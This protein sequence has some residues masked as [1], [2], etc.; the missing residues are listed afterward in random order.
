MGLDSHGV[1][2]VVWYVDEVLQGKIRPGAEIVVEKETGASAVL[3]GGGN[4][5]AVAAARATEHAVEKARNSGL[6]CVTVHNCHHV[7]RLGAFTES[8][9][10]DD[11]MICLATASW[12]VAGHWVAPWGGR[13]GRLATNPFSYAIPTGDDPLLLD[14]S[15]S[16]I[17]EGKIEVLRNLDEPLPDNFVLDGKGAVTRDPNAF[18]GP[19]R[20]TILP[21]GGVHGF[22][23]FGLSVLCE[24]LSGTLAGDRIRDDKI[25]GNRACFIVIDPGSFLPI[26]HFKAALQEMT[27]YLKD[28][29]TAEGFEEVVLPGEYHFRRRARRLREGVPVDPE[30]WAQIVAAAKRVDVELSEPG[31]S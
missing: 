6:S 1:I 14:M 22:K 21:F 31:D 19:P 16:A 11:D 9:A 12:P 26:D 20:G 13:E 23:G 30:T 4:F 25:Y 27:E 3:D 18:Y 5:G 10:R 29:P 24:V 15:T 2:R 17:S 28:T 7:A 8:V